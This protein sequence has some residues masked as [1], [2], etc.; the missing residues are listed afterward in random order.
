MWPCDETSLGINTFDWTVSNDK[1][2]RQFES[3]LLNM[4]V[5]FEVKAKAL[6]TRPRP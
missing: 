2:M 6:I 5:G 1:Y 3:N 4:N